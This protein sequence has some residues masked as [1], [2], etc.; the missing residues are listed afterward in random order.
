MFET[1]FASLKGSNA[2]GT[3]ITFAGPILVGSPSAKSAT[4]TIFLIS[5]VVE[6]LF[7]IQTSTFE[8]FTGL[9][10]NGN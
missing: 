1:L 2:P 9:L 7:V 8:I 4:A 6:F 5:T 3:G 10:I